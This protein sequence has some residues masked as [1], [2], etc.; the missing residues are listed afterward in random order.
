MENRANCCC[1]SCMIVVKGEADMV[2]VCHC[3][4]CKRRTGSAFGISSYFHRDKIQ[5][6][7]GEFNCYCFHHKAQSHDQER[8]FCKRCGTTLYW[9]ISTLAQMI[10]IAGGCFENESLLQPGYSISHLKKM[11]WLSL[12]ENWVIQE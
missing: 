9:K 11:S 10:G 4:N 8:Y 3:G 2:G 7:S 6:I 5:T 12:P 1:G